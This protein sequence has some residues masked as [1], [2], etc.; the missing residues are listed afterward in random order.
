[1][2]ESEEA[3]KLPTDERL[4]YEPPA[5]V[6]EA[7]FETLALSCAPESSV[8]PPACAAIVLS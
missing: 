7:V 8:F 4:A 6:S 1:M 2:K 3:T 5:V